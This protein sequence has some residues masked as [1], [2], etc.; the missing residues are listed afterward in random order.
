[1]SRVTGSQKEHRDT[2][3]N[4]VTDY[5]GGKYSWGIKETPPTTPVIYNKVTTDANWTAITT[6]LSDIR[7]WRLRERTGL[8]FYWSYTSS[9]TTYMTNLGGEIIEADTEISAIYVKRTASTDITVE[10]EVWSD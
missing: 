10:L 2:Q 7:C 4:R 1:M 5:G 6:G 8:P 3:T 9:P